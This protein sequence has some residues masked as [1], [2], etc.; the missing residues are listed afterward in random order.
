MSGAYICVWWYTYKLSYVLY[1]YQGTCTSTKCYLH[2]KLSVATFYKCRCTSMHF[3]M[4][5]LSYLYKV[6]TLKFGS[7][8]LVD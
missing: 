8:G 2:S 5:I 6:V 1:S 7:D 4:Y 3:H